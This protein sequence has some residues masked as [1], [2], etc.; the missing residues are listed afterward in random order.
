MGTNGTSLIGSPGEFR[1][2]VFPMKQSFLHEDLWG[3]I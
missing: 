3:G 2:I 1:R